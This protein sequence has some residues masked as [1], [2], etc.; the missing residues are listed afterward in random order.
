MRHFAV[1]F[2]L[3][4]FIGLVKLPSPVK[5]TANIQPVRLPTTCAVPE[6]DE[7]VSMG[8]GDHSRLSSS[9]IKGPPKSFRPLEFAVMKLLPAAVCQNAYRFI[10]WTNEFICAYD[11]V[12]HQAACPG[13]SGGPLVTRSDGTLIGVTSFASQGNR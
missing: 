12:N 2:K 10:E 11:S 7:V 3:C 8:T 4:F 6:S 1:V 13:D 9:E 5:F